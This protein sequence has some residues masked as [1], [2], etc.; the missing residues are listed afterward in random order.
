MGPG[1]ESHAFLARTGSEPIIA[2]GRI[3]PG[4]CFRPIT[5]CVELVTTGSFSVD[6][7]L[8]PVGPGVAPQL[9]IPVVDPRGA[10]LGT[11]RL[12]CEPADVDRVSRCRGTVAD[13]RVFPR[14]GGLVQAVVSEPP[15]TPRTTATPTRT[16][17][18]RPSSP[19]PLLPPV[20]LPGP[21]PAGPPPFLPPLPPLSVP[22]P[23]LPLPPDAIALGV[24]VIPE[25]GTLALVAT[26]LAAL[27]SLAGWRRLRRRVPPPTAGPP[28]PRPAPDADRHRP[29]PLG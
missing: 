13:P 23:P 1:Q 16:A 7:R 3:E 5:N 24:P 15:P 6:A 28:G 18:P 19:A 22:L 11:R 29:E 21:P 8:F 10:D 27:A 9:V 26:G 25:T 20:F 4:E 14:P 17:T 12:N 2:Q